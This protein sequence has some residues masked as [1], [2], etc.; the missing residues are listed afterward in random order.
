MFVRIRTAQVGQMKC[1]NS[2]ARLSMTYEWLCACLI[3]TYEYMFTHFCYSTRKWPFMVWKCLMSNLRFNPL[4][5]FTEKDGVICMFL[6]IYVLLW[7]VCIIIIILTGLF[8]RDISEILHSLGSYCT[9]LRLVQYDPSECNIS[10]IPL[11][12]SQYYIK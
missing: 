6:L 1:A 5:F 9:R 2:Y 11:K 10:D 4:V 8:F 12:A 3:V 7:I